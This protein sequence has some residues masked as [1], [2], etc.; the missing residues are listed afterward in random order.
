[1]GVRLPW[2]STGL[3]LLLLAGAAFVALDRS[4]STSAVP[5]AVL[6]SQTHLT[7]EY[8]QGLAEQYDR[9]VRYA[10]EVVGQLNAS[11]D[12]N[13]SSYFGGLAGHTH[14]WSSLELV[15]ASVHKA[16]YAVVAKAGVSMLRITVPLDSSTEA[17]VLTAPLNLTVSGGG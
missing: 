6:G 1:M 12:I 13:Q 10:T 7:E 4:V 3:T 5:A 2:L 8:A 9:D 14:P 11:P 16:Q 17:L 15:N